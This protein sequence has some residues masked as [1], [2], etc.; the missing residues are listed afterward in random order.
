MGPSFRVLSSE[1]FGNRDP[2]EIKICGGDAAWQ[3]D[4]L[5]PDMVEV[6]SGQKPKT[7]ERC[8]IASQ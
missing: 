3:A 7:K 5:G 2:Y 1:G 4:G 6:G 8:L